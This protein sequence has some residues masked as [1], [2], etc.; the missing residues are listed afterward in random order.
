[1][2]LAK[3]NVFKFC[4]QLN[5][6]KQHP[7][8]SSVTT[9]HNVERW[10]PSIGFSYDNS[11]IQHVSACFSNF[12]RPLKIAFILIILS[13]KGN[14]VISMIN[15]ISDPCGK[16]NVAY[17]FCFS[18]HYWPINTKMYHHCINA[19]CCN[20]A[21]VN[22]HVCGHIIAKPSLYCYCTAYVNL[23]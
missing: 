13:G 3:N 4:I 10:K 16:Y 17:V 19:Y 6:F 15:V 2:L 8:F 1:M 7:R 12:R 18:F 20:I 23:P 14:S 21:N 11:F 22:V 5:Y 9:K